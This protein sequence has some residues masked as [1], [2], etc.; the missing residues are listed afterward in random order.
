MS[1]TEIKTVDDNHIKHLIN[2]LA[3]DNRENKLF[4][5]TDM[6][7]QRYDIPKYEKL[8]HFFN[9][10][11]LLFWRP[12][13]YTLDSDRNHFA[14]FTK[15]QKKVFTQNLGFQI[16]LDTIQARG[17]KYLLDYCTNS[18]LEQAFTW[19]EAFENLH[20]YSY[21][22]IIRNIYPNPT[23][24]FDGFAKDE[25]ILKRVSG[26]TKYYDDLINSMDDS[27]HS[28][29]KKIYLTLVSVQILEAVR[30]YVSFACSYWFAENDYMMNNAKIIQLINRD[31]N[32]HLGLTKDIV[33]ILTE[34][35]SEGFQE[36][37]KECEPI[38][39][40]MWIDTSN[41]EIAWA[42]YLFEEGD[43]MGLSAEPLKQYMMYLVNQRMKVCGFS[44]LRFFDLNI[45]NPFPWIEKWIS[46]HNVQLA[47]Q[48]TDQTSYTVLGTSA[49]GLDDMSDLSDMLDF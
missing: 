7:L 34:N 6:G 3:V 29:K 40:Q 12:E 43:M 39:K 22:Y 47:N 10:Q 33:K 35:K 27:E 18:E 48:E 15:H 45:K 5:G 8:T 13:K 19:W 28:L 32:L 44:H 26:C 42:E 38:V 24:I 9:N 46:S 36:V 4:L 23:E 30:F 16:V 1:L 31:E 11:L 49:D 37:I 41:E 14:M 2:T 20:S 17:I 21:S 25:N